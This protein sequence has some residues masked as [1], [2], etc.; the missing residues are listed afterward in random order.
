MSASLLVAAI[1]TTSSVMRAAVLVLD[2][3]ECT[4]EGSSCLRDA[5]RWVYDRFLK[6][7]IRVDADVFEVQAS[8]ACDALLRGDE[9]TA[10]LVDDDLI[11][12]GE[13][14]TPPQIQLPNPA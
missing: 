9:T 2:L 10:G 1:A 14:R 6:S 8:G 12:A 5:Q 3:A 7:L 11:A 13:V 4:D